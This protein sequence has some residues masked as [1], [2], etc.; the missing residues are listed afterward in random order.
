MRFNS[1]KCSP[2]VVTEGV[3][4]IVADEGSERGVCGQRPTTSEPVA[5]QTCPTDPLARFGEPVFRVLRTRGSACGELK[6]G[7]GIRVV[8]VLEEP[9][10][11][12]N[13]ITLRQRCCGSCDRGDNSFGLSC[14]IFLQSEGREDVLEAVEKV[15]FEG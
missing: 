13:G 5:Q 1:Q 7:K 6:V 9:L 12:G 3:V 8:K 14:S 10:S 2:Q 4:R 15:I 11:R